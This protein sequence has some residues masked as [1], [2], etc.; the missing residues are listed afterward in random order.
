MPALPQF[1]V[2]SSLYHL[3]HN[4]EAIR[5]V[6]VVVV[7]AAVVVAAAVSPFHGVVVFQLREAVFQP[8]AIFQQGLQ[9]V[10]VVRRWYHGVMFAR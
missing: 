3:L 2:L 7:V 1:C 8:V 9:L 4:V 6:V 10:R 5:A